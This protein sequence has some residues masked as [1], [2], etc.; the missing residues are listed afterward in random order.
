MKYLFVLGLYL[1]IGSPIAGAKTC[2]VDK[3][4]TSFRNT[5]ICGGLYTF[6][7]QVRATG[8]TKQAQLSQ[9]F[10]DFT[11]RL[12]RYNIDNCQTSKATEIQIRQFIENQKRFCVDSCKGASSVPFGDC[13]AVCT[14][15]AEKVGDQFSGYLKALSYMT[16]AS[17][18]EDESGRKSSGST[19]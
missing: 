12:E 14:S 4:L 16:T 10:T 1:T 3:A 7:R 13:R 19:R 15:M 8:S 5:E 6:E 18:E 11:Q 9:Y 17:C 2:S